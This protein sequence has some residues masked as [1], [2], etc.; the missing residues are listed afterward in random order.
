LGHALY[1]THG[2]SNS[3]IGVSNSTIGVSNSTI[4]VSNSTIRCKLFYNWCKQFYNWCKQF[5]NWCKQFYNSETRTFLFKLHH[6]ILGINVRVAHYNP[7]RSPE[8]SF[9]KLGK[10]LPAE[11]ET[12]SHFFWYC[13]YTAQSINQQFQL[14]F[15]FPVDIDNFFTGTGPDANYSEALMIQFD[16]IKYIL[17]LTKLRKRLPTVHSVRSDF[18]Y[19]TGATLGYNNKLNALVTECNWLRRNGGDE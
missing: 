16:I 7:E 2:V 17:W 13:P 10:N 19:L 18:F 8:C 14:V 11:R 12:I 3:T 15:N 5:Y 1:A 9:C 4:G 6:N